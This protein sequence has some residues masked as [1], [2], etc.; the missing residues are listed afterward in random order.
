MAEDT[1]NFIEQTANYW[2]NRGLE[3]SPENTVENFTL[4]GPRKR[5][6]AL[7]QL[8]S[9]LAKVEPTAGDLRE[10]TEMVG[11]RRNLDS[12]HHALLKANR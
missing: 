9:E 10:Y 12:V 5:A 2:R 4:Y 6:D 1:R 8:D 3:W 11:L 7:D